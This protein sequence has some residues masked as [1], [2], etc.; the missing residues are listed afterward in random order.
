MKA[1][2]GI[3]PCHAFS[4]KQGFTGRLSV[5]AMIM[6]YKKVVNVILLPV[7][8]PQKTESHLK[9]SIGQSSGKSTPREEEFS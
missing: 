4:S 6:P 1:L 9:R 5:S 8:R 3:D 2:T 7:L